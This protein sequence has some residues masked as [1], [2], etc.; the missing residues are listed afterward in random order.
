MLQIVSLQG[1]QITNLIQVTIRQQQNHEFMINM[2][3]SYK[4]KTLN[5]N[6]WLYNNQ[7]QPTVS[8]SV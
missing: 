6:R 8:T 1:K 5:I 7:H 3:V 4:I 2:Y